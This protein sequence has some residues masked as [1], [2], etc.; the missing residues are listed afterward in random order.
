MGL[1]DY[2]VIQ[3]KGFDLKSK[4]EHGAESALTFIKNVD[5]G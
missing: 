5:A 4:T 2:G 3:F 1:E